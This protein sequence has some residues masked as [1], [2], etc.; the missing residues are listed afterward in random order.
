MKPGKYSNLMQITVLFILLLALPCGSLPIEDDTL[1]VWSEFSKKNECRELMEWLRCRAGERLAGAGQCRLTDIK[2]PPFFGAL[3]LFI[4]LKKGNTIRGCYGAFTHAM[5]DIRSLLSDYLVG[6]LTRDPR[7]KPIDV[8]ELAE[9][10]IILTIATVPS[11]VSDIGTVD[12]HRYGVMVVCNGDETTVFVPA[13]VR[14]TSYVERF[15]RG[16][17]CQASIFRAITIR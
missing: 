16:T 5:T 3:G 6:A 10:D 1:E 17:S 8:A 9:T 11:P 2:A 12:M 14:T 7:Y 13:E 15:M 4:T